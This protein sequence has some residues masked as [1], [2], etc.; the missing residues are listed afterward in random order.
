MTAPTEQGD[1]LRGLDLTELLDTETGEDR[2][3][4]SLFFSQSLRRRASHIT[5]FQ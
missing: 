3:A 4:E 2:G 1:T 5:E